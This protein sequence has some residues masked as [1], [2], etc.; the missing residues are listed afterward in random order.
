M[1]SSDEGEAEFDDGEYADPPLSDLKKTPS[2]K[3]R[4]RGGDQIEDEGDTASNGHKRRS[5]RGAVVSYKEEDDDAEEEE[6]EY[7]EEANGDGDDGDESADEDDDDVPLM[8]LKSPQKK[9]PSKKNGSK[10]KDP[11][12][13]KTKTTKKKKGVKKEASV[14]FSKTTSGGG[15]GSTDYK[16][17]SFALY[18]TDSSKGLLIQRLLCR[19]WY[20]ITWPDPADIPDKPPPN[21]DAMDGFPGVYVCTRGEEVG[22][23]KD[24]RDKAKAPNFNNFVKMESVELRD[25]LVKAVKE[26]RRQLVQAEGPGTST[27]KDLNA[28]LNWAEKLNVGKADKEAATILKA[29]K[30]KLPE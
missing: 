11:V 28:M 1:S 29:N 3:A 21:F 13:K 15:S 14:S 25:L 22:T 20:A 2:G 8:S 9:S 17:P 26:Q 18:G 5:G 19:W 10:A 6:E 30:L 4:V 23:I 24:F 27:E 7:D 16:S 12:K